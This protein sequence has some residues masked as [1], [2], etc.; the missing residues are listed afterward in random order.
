MALPPDHWN[1]AGDISSQ[2]IDQIDLLSCRAKSH[3]EFLR[4]L[5]AIADNDS[6]SL[7][8]LIDA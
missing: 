3:I 5:R 7:S 8:K 1:D 4:G 6:V 2:M